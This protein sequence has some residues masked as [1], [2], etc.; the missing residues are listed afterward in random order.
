MIVL[1][2]ND[3]LKGVDC[4][5]GKHHSCDIKKVYIESDAMKHLVELCAPYNNILL[6]ADGN[7]YAAA[8]EKTEK[9][10][11]GKKLTRVLF[12]G[13]TILIPNEEAIDRVTAMTA[14]ID[15]IIGIGSGV[16]QDLCKYVSHTEK[17]PYFIVAT[18]P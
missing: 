14:G 11:D 6:V 15:L 13:E 18:A 17:I 16:I 1:K 9:Y 10:L 4:A 5:C 3:L 12:S 7:T 2:I 8:G